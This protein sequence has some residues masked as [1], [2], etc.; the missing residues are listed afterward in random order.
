MNQDRFVW[1]FG[2]GLRNDNDVAE[3]TRIV[4]T[5]AKHKYNGAV[6]SAGLDSLCKQPPEYF[7]RLAEVRKACER[8]GLELIPAVFSVGYGGGTLGHNR[9]LAEGLPVNDAP[10]VVRSG[11]ARIV[12]DPTVR[13]VN[14]DFE[15]FQ[16]HRFSGYNFHDQPGEVSFADTQVAHSGKA[17]LRME[18]FQA[19]AHGHGRVMQ[20]V[21][22]KP[23]RCYRVTIWVKTEGLQPSGSFHVQVLAGNRSLAPRTFD[24]P[25]TSDWRKLT[26]IFN[27]LTFDKVRL[28]AGVWGGRAGKFWLDD[29]TLE[30]VGPVNVLRRPGTPVVVKSAD[31]AVTYEEGKDYALPPDPNFNPYRVEQDAMPI[32]IV[33][34]SRIKDGQTLRVSWYHPMVIH[35]SQVT[36]CMAEPEVYDIWEHEAK[37]LAETL[38]PR[39]VLLNMDEVRM[40][41]TCAACRGK[42]M[43]RLLGECITKQV[44]ILRRYNPNAAIYI[45]SDMLDPNHN[46]HGDYYLVQGD[47]TGSW[48]HVPKDLIIAVWGGA[49]REKSLKFFSEQGFRILVACYYD[50]DD[51]DTTRGWLRLAQQTPRVRGF[52]YTT[53]LKKYALVPEFGDLVAGK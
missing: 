3:I 16:G 10:F 52:M 21:S 41:G 5:A 15:Q 17:S 35:E 40:G 44:Q 20:E 47:F 8:S 27:S 28:Y 37:L 23:H 30:E 9:H 18:N 32:R 51:L 11:E 2:W 25:P 4:E 26:M 14:G 7:R 46:A 34:S 50:A 1:I 39:R 49:P 29:W 12:P 45:W 33:P 22:V 31:G 38:R 19:N 36:I 13:L 48:N 53:W 24:V 6:L 43:A 42:D